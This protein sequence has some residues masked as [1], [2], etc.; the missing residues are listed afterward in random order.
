MALAAGT[1]NRRF[2]AQQR[3]PGED[4]GGQPLDTWENV[5]KF[6]G[7]IKGPTGLGSITGLQDNVA[8]SIDKYS[9]RSRFRTTLNVG[10]RI[11]PN[12]ADDN[13]I[14]SSPFEIRQI[15]QDFE[16]KE[17]TDFVCELGGSDG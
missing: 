6:Y 7:N 16:R 15:R 1:L 2:T 14:E 9:I 4:E 11:C 8:A 13:P 12:D 3:T 17:Y 5:E 10:M